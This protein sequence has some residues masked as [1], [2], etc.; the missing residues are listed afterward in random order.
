LSAADSTDGGKAASPLRY[1]LASVVGN[2]LEWY[3]FFLFAA[4]SALVFDKLFFSAGE[5]PALAVLASLA[6][7]AVGFAARPL[8]GL[9][10]GS[11]GDR[12]GRTAA[13]LWTFSLM[14]A[15]TFSIG[16]L[17]THEQAG[18][19]AVAGLV[20]L[21]IAQGIAAGG[22]WGG[23]VLLIAEN[24][25]PERRG[26]LTAWSQAG[27]GLGFVLASSALYLAQRLPEADFLAWGWRIPFLLSMLIVPVGIAIRRSLP[28]SADYREQD[29]AN[30][31]PLRTLVRRYPREI[32]AAIGIRLAENGG[33]QLMLAFALSFGRGAGVDTG[34]LLAAATIG[35]LADSFMMPVFGALSDRVGR[36]RVYAFGIVVL[37]LFAWPFFL[38]IATNSAPL[39]ILAFVVGNGLCHAAMIGVQPTLYSELFDADVRYSGLSTAHEVSAV[40]VGW[41]PLAATAL[42]TIYGTVEPVVLMMTLLCAV[43][44]ISLWA[45]PKRV[46][47]A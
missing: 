36:V 14:G 25:P 35:M 46:A 31:M 33:S 8:G 11:F 39:V 3:D 37:A 43:S 7:Y 29:H 15:A 47:G 24:S 9:I 2:A 27:V 6:T 28:E 26:F 4:A 44:L 18:L 13:L 1:V 22:E 34:L 30:A 40:I 32:A 23:G 42:M 45:L 21:R 38:L 5:D 17:P 41:A 10:F 16:L 12:H 20:A 19:W